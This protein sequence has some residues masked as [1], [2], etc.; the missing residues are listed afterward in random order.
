MTIVN[1][2]NVGPVN[3]PDG[4]SDADIVK[5]IET[6]IIP[7]STKKPEAPSTPKIEEKPSLLA[8]TTLQPEEPITPFN[9]PADLESLP[10]LDASKM[11]PTAAETK[12][13]QFGITPEM[14]ATEQALRTA[15][16]AAY[17]ASS[18]FEQGWLGGARLI[19]DVTGVGK[20]DIEGVSKQLSNESQAVQN[21]FKEHYGLNLASSIGSSV[22]QNI[23]TMYAG[24]AEG[25][26]TAYS[27][28]FG[29]SFLQGYDEGRNKDLSP[30]TSTAYGAINGAA[31][32]LGE[33]IGF[34]KLTEAIK[35]MGKGIPAKELA[36]KAAH[37]LVN[38]LAGEELT[39]A[40]QFL[41]DVGFGVTKY[42]SLEE[43][44]TAYCQSFVDT[45]LVTVGQ[46]LV[47]G[48]TGMVANSVLKQL[49]ETHS[50]GEEGYDK[51]AEQIEQ[52]TQNAVVP[53]QTNQA[54]PQTNQ[55]PPPG[56]VIESAT[57][58]PLPTVPLNA[59]EQQAQVN[60]NAPIAPVAQTADKT[61]DAKVEQ[62]ALQ[63]EEELG[64][65]K[66]QALE[67][68]KT[69]VEEEQEH[70][71]GQTTGAVSGANQP[72][73]SVPTVGTTS[74]QGAV[75]PSTV[76]L[77][78]PVS[79]VGGLNAGEAA[80]PSALDPE[81]AARAE[82]RIDQLLAEAKKTGKL[83]IKEINKLAKDLDIV[84]SKET[85]KTIGAIFDVLNPP[86]QTT[87]TTAP[88][89][90]E[91]IAPQA[92]PAP[93]V[94][95]P[96]EEVKPKG[97]R[98]RKPTLITPEQQVEAKAKKQANSAANKAAGKTVEAAAK[99]LDNEEPVREDFPTQDSYLEAGMRH[100]SERNQAIDTLHE[101]AN[102][103][104]Y[105]N[106][107]VGKKAQEA[108]NHPSV[109][110]QEKANAKERREL[111]RREAAKVQRSEITNGEVNT[112]Y[113]SFKTVGDAL[114]YI[115]QKG[116]RFEKALARRLLPFLKNVQY[117]V[118]NDNADIPNK[119]TAD[120]TT[121][122]DAFKGAT[123]M[124]VETK[125]GQY[126]LLRGA[127][128]EHPELQGL[129]NAT[130]LHEALHAATIGLINKYL[131]YPEGKAPAYLQKLVD[132]LHAIM[133]NA[134]NRY[135]RGMANGEQFSPE[136][137]HLFNEEERGGINI[138][139][140]LKEFITYGMTNEEV[141]KFLLDTRGEIGKGEQGFFKN[142][143]N[144][145]VNTL[146]SAFGMED[147]HMSGMQ[148]LILVTEGLLNYA[149]T[150]TPT[151]VTQT[152]VAAARKIKMKEIERKLL[153][154]R[155]PEQ[156]LKAVGEEIKTD[157][158]NKNFKDLARWA[159]VTSVKALKQGLNLLSLD[160]TIRLSNIVNGPIS[161]LNAIDSLM[162]SMNTMRNRLLNASSVKAEQLASFV[163][164]NPE[165]GVHLGDAMH[166]STLSNIDPTKYP[167][168]KTAIAAA[169]KANPIN[170]K[171]Q[172]TERQN[173]ITDMYE[174]WNKLTP[175]GKELFVMARDYY[176][177]M[178][179]LYRKLLD[180]RI[181]ESGLPEEDQKKLMASTRQIYEQALKSNIYFPL[182]R[183]GKYWVRLSEGPLKGFYMF[184]SMNAREAFL[185]DY[186]PDYK[187][188]VEKQKA[189][190]GDD[191]NS[192]RKASF[193]ESTMLNNIFD[194]LPST[195]EAKIETLKD[196]IYQMYLMTLPEAS[197]RRNFIHRKGT[198]GFSGDIV[199]NFASSSTTYANQLS[200]LEYGNKLLNSIDSAEEALKGNPYG[201]DRGIYFVDAIRSHVTQEVN[202][203]VDDSI[204]RT[205]AK[206]ANRFSFMWMLATPK[207]FFVQLSSLT[208][209]GT[210]VLAANPNYSMVDI[211]KTMMDYASVWKSTGIMR[212]NVDGDRV[213][214]N[215][216]VGLGSRIKNNPT[217]A[218]AFQTMKDMGIAEDTF[219]SSM[220][221]LGKRPTQVGEP[222]V[223]EQTKK[224]AA[225]TARLFGEIVSTSER[226]SREIM[227]M[228]AFELA[229]NHS[230]DFDASIAQASKDTYEALFNYSRANR[231]AFIKG[232]PIR[233]IAFQFA[234]YKVQMT[235]FLIR[236]FAGMVKPLDGKTR[237]EA[238]IKF[239][240]SLLGVG[241][242]AG[243]TGLPLYGVICGLIDLY[244]AAIAG[245]FGDD[246]DDEDAIT[247]RI[248]GADAWFRGKYLP[249]VLGEKYAPYA[250]QGPISA[251]T[252]LDIGTSIS[253]DNTWFRETA[254]K[255]NFSD[256]MAQFLVSMTGPTVSL[257]GN[258]ASGIHD[259]ASGQIERGIEKVVPTAIKGP[260]V[261]TRQAKEGE[262]TR[263][264]LEIEP[265]EYFNAFKLTAR[266]LGFSDTEIDR[267]VKSNFL[268]RDSA[269]KG[270]T[271][272]SE[273]FQKMGLAMEND[274]E[275]AYVKAR[276]KYQASPYGKVDPITPEA[277]TAF[278]NAFSAKK[279][280][281]YQGLRLNPKYMN[282]LGS[283]AEG[284]RSK[285]YK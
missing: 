147:Y 43:A 166:R 215:I 1:V 8:G 236:N 213:L 57:G 188:L 7:Q 63:L 54:P 199:R 217:L 136:L 59:A 151:N 123:G 102:H 222:T 14:G 200:K 117:I 273:T 152:E 219:V 133:Q 242:Y 78:S 191:V 121:L 235:S 209:L 211:V 174:A 270:L 19:S 229:Y 205:V 168:A 250:E 94:A 277:E 149:E 48:G 279:G 285:E 124:Y 239:F 119:R 165:Q 280:A 25:L 138:L 114:A 56:P 39:N 28:M 258:V 212:T 26:P 142:L 183:Y 130:F 3:F 225:T 71:E 172:N 231:P 58:T 282:A 238:S 180:K 44:F 5:A 267:V 110:E 41:N 46:G 2:P 156:L 109:T 245:L 85:Q 31:E 175:K 55:A 198:A 137:Q 252:G 27:L 157:N 272:K 204:G 84:P 167:N 47:L 129:N 64:F 45:A 220:L 125:G 182:M 164:K 144:R 38:D 278:Q 207:Q 12:A 196:S 268:L 100:R 92:T 66:E 98:G 265:A 216:S 60:A 214:T 81:L 135:I 53:P 233:E 87:E 37:Y 240:G 187:N 9:S 192:L 186:V 148:D 202:P 161:G 255:R 260:L 13:A 275:E 106:L 70:G 18:A 173:D 176:A 17:R 20:E 77:A 90:T 194:K 218:K 269:Q 237:K 83:N 145:F 40:I 62:R 170:N 36:S 42:K 68:A 195:G 21:T 193:N 140:D 108:L 139:E 107:T 79:S 276:D 30:A 103:G 141:Q 143:F 128:F 160:D 126:I 49:R 177:S 201:K 206:L 116:T 155:N 134:E 264:G 241:M 74:T 158:I 248:A 181:A 159:R 51:A 76:G 113:N 10:K 153:A 50:G 228:S 86:S 132:S 11:G 67:V 146:R 69:Q 32:V 72:S 6:D 263:Q 184:E 251:A 203:E 266:S 61:V 80:Q 247:F 22:L 253:L 88:Q 91:A 274:D 89:A 93:E 101:A 185:E 99:V 111:R 33:S 35:A 179:T 254:D 232:G 122:V 120:G 178:Y 281:A 127:N 226:L 257:I 244:G 23:P 262:K 227:F 131:T 24:V 171:S 150:S 246:D 34:P 271:A 208:T 52:A 16:N 283:I 243:V 73:V 15:K 82:M 162:T 189:D 197:F 261:A 210:S 104:P 4:M 190:K 230:K 96:A 29:Q 224:G 284:T 97:K 163:M 234:T 154:S 221:E 95:T 105:K 223:W 115:M 75:A 169:E 259:M 118:V 256:A 65:S 112:K 249:S